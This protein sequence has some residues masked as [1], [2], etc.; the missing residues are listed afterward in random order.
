M[1]ISATSGPISSLY[2]SIGLL[3]VLASVSNKAHAIPRGERNIGRRDISEY[4]RVK[5]R[6]HSYGHPCLSAYGKRYDSTVRRDTLQESISRN[7]QEFELPS[8]KDE[9]FYILPNNEFRESS[10]RSFMRTLKGT[11]RL[12]SNLLSSLVNQL[13][14]SHR[15]SRRSDPNITNK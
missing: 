12:Y 7:F 8:P 10:D 3:M 13:I 14:T 1:R 9:L 15:H 6:C 5:G 4:R 11:Q 2:L